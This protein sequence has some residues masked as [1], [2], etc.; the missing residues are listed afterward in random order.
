MTF[1]KQVVYLYSPADTRFDKGLGHH[2]NAFEI[3]VQGGTIHLLSR[4]VELPSPGNCRPV[5][6]TRG[7]FYLQEG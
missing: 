5:Q 4:W 3:I 2:L 1:D 7:R 6:C